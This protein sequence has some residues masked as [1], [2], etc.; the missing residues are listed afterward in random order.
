MAPTE[1]NSRVETPERSPSTVEAYTPDSS[2]EGY[3]SDS[4]TTQQESY[5]VIP[6]T[7]ADDADW[8]AGGTSFGQ[9]RLSGGRLTDRETATP[10]VYP[11]E[12]RLSNG[13]PALLLDIGSVGNLA[14]DEWVKQQATLAVQA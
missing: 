11:V 6:N 9:Q 14:G 10:T 12:T 7:F 1:S 2:P 5:V 3:V 8:T 4:A 13:K